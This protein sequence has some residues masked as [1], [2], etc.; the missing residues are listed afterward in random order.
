MT[1]LLL[2]LKL[3]TKMIYTN[4]ISN[5]ILYLPGFAQ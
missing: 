4:Q 3:M 5:D 2:Q 1:I